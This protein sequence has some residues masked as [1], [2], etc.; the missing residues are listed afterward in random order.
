[1]SIEFAAK[2]EGRILYVVIGLLLLH[3]T[4]ISIQVEDPAGTVL[5]KRWV[6]AASAPILNGSSNVS[7]G[8][9]NLWTSYLWLHG[10]RGENA[11][12]KE[13]VRQLTLLN[14]SL[15]Q[16][17]EENARLR[18]LLAFSA[19]LPGQTLGARVIGRAPNFLANTLYLDRGSADGVRADQAVVSDAGIIGRTVL[20]TRNNSQVQLL[21]NADASI[22]VMI[23]R[24]RVP[25]VVR[26]TENLLLNLNF[27]SN[28][29]D[30]NVGDTLV[31]SGLDG[32]FPKGLSVGKVVESQKGKTGF[33]TIR[34]EPGADVV[35][36]EEVLILLGTPKVV[37]DPPAPRA[38]K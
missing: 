5:I 22:G 38:G 36:L 16:A 29:E 37:A 18:R 26:G 17:Q 32:I 21:T 15:A 35:R 34:V 7:R 28:T 23:E 1:M 24:T 10:A 25:G 12:L 8:L 3:L 31:T 4:L 2:G 19:A 27:I 14:S 30:V 6:L 33:R 9:G 20:V 11:R 13:D